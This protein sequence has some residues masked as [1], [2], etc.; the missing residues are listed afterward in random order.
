MLPTVT[1]PTPPLQLIVDSDDEDDDEID[2]RLN[3]TYVRT[4]DTKNKAA[5]VADIKRRSSSS[6]GVDRGHL[7]KH[8]HLLNEVKTREGK[9][10]VNPKKKKQK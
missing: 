4:H 5:V 2:A 6:S 3:A 9:G 8:M 1:P 10:T 7:V